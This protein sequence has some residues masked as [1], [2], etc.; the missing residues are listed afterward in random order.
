MVAFGDTR[1]IAPAY[2]KWAGQVMEMQIS[3]EDGTD[4]ARAVS[5]VLDALAQE[6]PLVDLVVVRE[7]VDGAMYGGQ[8]G[9]GKQG[10]YLVNGQRLHYSRVREYGWRDSV[11][12]LR[13][14]VDPA[15]RRIE[16]DATEVWLLPMTE[17]MRQRVI[18]LGVRG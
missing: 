15:A 3:V 12:W 16:K 8:A 9:S 7:P 18:I 14:H 6:A 10:A 5:M 11:L 4:K 1:Y 13:E 2:D 17:Q